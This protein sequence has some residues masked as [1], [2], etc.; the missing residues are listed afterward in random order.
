MITELTITMVLTGLG[1][2][3]VPAAV[4]LWST[5]D[6]RRRRAWRL[7]RLLRKR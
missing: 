6:E 2:T 1:V 5:D 7:L 4:F 3:M